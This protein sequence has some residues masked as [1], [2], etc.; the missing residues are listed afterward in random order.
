[1]TAAAFTPAVAFE[2]RFQSLHERS[3]A[4]IFPCDR[5]GQVDLD[6]LSDRSRSNYIFAK[7]MRGRAYAWPIVWAIASA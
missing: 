5:E 4:L 7:A 1:M 3:P 2:L 6:G